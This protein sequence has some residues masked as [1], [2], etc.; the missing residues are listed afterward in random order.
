MQIDLIIRN[1]NIITLDDAH[2]SARSV[3]VHHG[4]ILATGE[5]AD[6]E[7]L[8][9]ASIVDAGGATVTPGFGDAHNHMAWYGLALDEIDLSVAGTLEQLYD[10][11]A[12]RAGSLPEDAWVVGS[13]YDDTVLGGHPAAG[14]LDRAG[15]GRP[16]WLKARS[17]HMCTVSTA[18]LDQVGVLDDSVQV[19]AGGVVVTDDAGRPTGVLEEQAQNLVVSL[20]VP[21][22][23]DTLADAIGRAAQRYSAEG[24]T[25]V[26]ECGIGA[27]WLGKSPVE[28][29][30]YQ[31]AR[32]SGS[33]SVRVQ[34]MPTVDA[35]HPIRANAEDD[36]SFGLDLGMHTGFG[37]DLLR[38]G[39]MKL[40]LDGSMLGRTAAVHEDFCDRPGRGYFQDDPDHMRARMIEAHCA[41][42]NVAAHAIGDRAIDLALDAFAE[43]QG[44]RRR[45]EARHRIEHASLT[46]D[47]HLHRMAEL[48]VTPVP[49]YRFLYEIGDTMASAVGPDRL[50]NLYRHRSFLDAGLRVPGSSDRP[51]ADGAPLLAMQSMVERVT[52]S[53]AALSPQERVDATT[54]LRA[55]T[56]DCAWIAGEEHDRGTISPGKLADLV[57]LDDDPTTVPSGSIGAIQVLATF[58]GGRATHGADHVRHT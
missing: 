35:L 10:L 39:P 20:V 52:S 56:V 34:L 42:W 2:P 13:G 6:L 45:P 58:L 22:P 4:R 5:S 33:L 48:S 41:G 37:D 24:L 27:G 47:E 28:L 54:A 32:A 15:G 36:V 21:Y 19:P 55:Y 53:G 51:V 44:R 50:A 26:T 8:T 17:G 57:L 16:V 46:T 11:V 23:L 30:A 14:R 40:W 43:A 31:R 29:A 7:G 3:A 1:A 38:L 49:Q 18:V 25:Q 9:A 12:E